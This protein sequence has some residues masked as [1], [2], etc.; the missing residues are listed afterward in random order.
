[1]TMVP[2]RKKGIMTARAIANSGA[3]ILIRIRLL[4]RKLTAAME[5]CMKFTGATK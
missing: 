1:M 5:R 2:S 3:L 4:P